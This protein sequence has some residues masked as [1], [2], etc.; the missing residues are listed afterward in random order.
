MVAV[1]G[2]RQA[3]LEVAKRLEQEGFDGIYCPSLTDNL[4]FCTALAFAT[5]EIKFGT[6]ITNMYARHPHDF[7]QTAAFIHEV[8]NGRFRFGVGVSHGPTHARMG[9]KAGKPLG[10]MRQ[11]VADLRAAVQ[12]IS[13][14]LPPIVL[15]AL[16]QKMTQLAAEI[17]E[18]AVWANAARSHMA[19][20]LRVI[21]E[22][23]MRDDNFFVGNMVPTCIRTIGRP[24]LPSCAG[25]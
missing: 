11:F 1:G 7:A 12:P 9:I 21:P 25:S 16:R 17:A 6:S 22:A 19:A 15:A 18:G 14:A 3:S 20:S 2:R 13:G 10:E 8:S 4:A 24:R 5:H 23:K